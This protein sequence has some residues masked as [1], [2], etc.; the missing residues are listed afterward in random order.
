MRQDVKS[1]EA[2]TRAAQIEALQI[3]RAARGLSDPLNLLRHLVAATITA[4]E[5]VA[6]EKRPEAAE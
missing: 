5:T 3:R 6:V 2:T 1:I 4:G